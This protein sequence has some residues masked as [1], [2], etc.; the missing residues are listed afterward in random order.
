MSWVIRQ[1]LKFGLKQR[2]RLA[3]LPQYQKSMELKN[4]A[5]AC[6]VLRRCAGARLADDQR[7]SVRGGEAFKCLPRDGSTYCLS[8]YACYVARG[9]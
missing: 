8:S 6:E 5:L 9:R 4:A 2:L 7:A 1:L 3:A